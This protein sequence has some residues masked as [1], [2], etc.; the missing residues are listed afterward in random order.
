M[1]HNSCAAVYLTSQKCLHFSDLAKETFVI[2]SMAEANDSRVDYQQLEYPYGKH[3]FLITFI[4]VEM[5]SFK[6]FN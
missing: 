1:L 2:N 5:L 6:S 3:C 4:N